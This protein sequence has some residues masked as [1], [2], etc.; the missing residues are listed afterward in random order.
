MA[1]KRLTT[2]EMVQLSLPWVTPG[3][4]EHKTIAGVPELA[5]VLPRIAAGHQALHDAQ[6]GSDDPRLAKI[7][8]EEGALDLRHDEIVR[9]TYWFLTALAWLVGAGDMADALLRLRDLLFLEG[10]QAAQKTYRE[11]AGAAELMKTRIA[12]DATAKKQLKELP[13]LKTNLAHYVDELAQKAARLGE[14]EHERAQIAAG[15]PGD[16]AKMVAARNQWIRA[17]NALVT[18]GE[19]AELDESTQQA[20][21]GALR[22]AEKVAD[23]R[24]VPPAEPDPA[25]APAPLAAAGPTP[26]K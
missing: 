15:G 20:I 12:N 24:K 18:N 21:F 6:P 22:V 8:E 3:T 4:E 2:G 19:L 13:V 10:L 7:Q 25:A 5:S 17:V 26:S 14:L 16:P 9:G 23:R 1:L 11:E